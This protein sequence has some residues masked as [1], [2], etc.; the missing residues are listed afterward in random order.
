M[1]KT[2]KK[3][4]NEL[5]INNKCC[6]SCGAFNP[7]FVAGFST[8]SADFEIL[9]KQR[10]EQERVELE[11]AENERIEQRRRKGVEAAEKRQQEQLAKEENKPA[12][13]PA[14]YKPRHAMRTW[15]V[16]AFLIAFIVVSGSFTYLH[17]A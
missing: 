9:E 7:Y 1:K 12:S 3:C 5:N 10:L 2:C 16:A 17:F 11:V 4:G 8:G 6:A 14:Y 15:T 13:R